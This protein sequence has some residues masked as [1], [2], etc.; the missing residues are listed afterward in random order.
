VA[1]LLDETKPQKTNA[2]HAIATAGILIAAK[3][4][5]LRQASFPPIELKGIFANIAI[6]ARLIP[7]KPSSLRGVSGKPE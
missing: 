7:I 6:P 2:S 4:K 5:A 1:K 3:S